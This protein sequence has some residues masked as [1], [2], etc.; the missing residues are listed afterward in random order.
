MSTI[1]LDAVADIIVTELILLGSQGTSI[2]RH[3]AMR[4]INKYNIP[5]A[6][7][8]SALQQRGFKLILGPCSLCLNDIVKDSF[9]ACKG[10][11]KSFHSM[12]GVN[13]FCDSKC[14]IDLITKMALKE[15][16]S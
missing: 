16:G 3:M 2:I 15:I 11:N 10:C 12:C 4:M 7:L 14:R 5:K 13:E 8:I 1:T 9:Q 6:E